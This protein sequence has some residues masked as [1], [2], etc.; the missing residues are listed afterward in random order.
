MALPLSLTQP[1]RQG[2]LNIGAGWRA[3][4]APFN[5]A[6]AV[7]NSSTLLGPTIYDYAVS[8]KFLDGTPVP[9]WTDL[10]WVT[11][12]KFTP[13]S[14]IG[15]IM[16]GYRMA[17]RAKYR[18]DVA[19]KLSFTF[20]ESTRWAYKIATGNA[21]Y[22]I[23]ATTQTA[24]SDAPFAAT[25][26]PA[27]PMGA[28]GYIATGLASG[29]TN[30]LPTLFVPSGSGA[31]FPAGTYIVCDQDYN[32]SQFGFV[33][34]AG[35]NVFQGAVT[36]VDFIR[37]TSD[38]VAM[39]VQVVAG[40]AAGQDALILN[41]AFIGGGNNAL[42]DTPNIAPSAGAKVQ[43]LV[44]YATR[45]GGTTITEWSGIFVLDT[46]DGSQLLRYYPRLAPD[47]EP[48]ISSA[49]VEGINSMQKYSLEAALEAMAFDDPWDGE[50]V[51]SY[52]AYFPRG[53]QQISH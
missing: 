32:T 19:E 13:G 34:D 20:E 7:T 9:P 21:V 11:K 52:E 51:V 18:G 44:G 49:N 53:G 28:S 16:T 3:H 39:V 31:L 37:K 41:Q 22:N 12:F 2:Q 43:A 50:T 46:I 42:S 27:I 6:L 35:A 17:A 30:G 5:Q 14:K 38:Y 33:G 40:A 1:L 26:T 29:P 45:G 48:G 23:L 47:Q 15:T 25:G 24:I 36:D 10:G 8:K 4:F